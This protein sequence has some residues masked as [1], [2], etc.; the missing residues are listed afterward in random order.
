MVGANEAVYVTE[1]NGIHPNISSLSWIN[2]ELRTIFYLR[3]R[4]PNE[5]LSAVNP[6]KMALILRQGKSIEM[7]FSEEESPSRSTQK[8]GSCKQY[9]IEW[10]RV[11]LTSYVLRYFV[12]G[13]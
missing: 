7:P 3:L 11:L 9:A 10:N 1:L 6:R 4:M 2:K 13:P 12:Y 8:S 5:Q